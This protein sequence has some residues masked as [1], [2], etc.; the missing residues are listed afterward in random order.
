[1]KPAL[2]RAFRS[3]SAVLALSGMALSSSA[4]A[5][6]PAWPNTPL[7]RVEVLALLE[8]LNA[9]LL[10]NDSATLTLDGWCSSHHLAPAGAKIVADRVKDADKP[11][12]PEIRAALQVGATEPVRYRRVRLRC[13]AHILSEA[14]NWYVPARLTPAM[15]SALDTTDIAF[16]RA[17]GPLHFRR[18][19]LS[20]KLLWSPLPAGWDNLD[21]GGAPIAAMP[22]STLPIPDRLIEHRA[23]LRTPDGVPFSEVVE[24]YS[25]EILAFPPP[26]FAQR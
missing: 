3:G 16:G 21:N 18:Q 7:A 19:T 26:I 4:T 17:V 10:S 8:S 22:G 14:D 12:T 24:T 25:G 9:T 15:N 20:A 2:F 6:T 5:A 1:M 11:A 23:L 13:G